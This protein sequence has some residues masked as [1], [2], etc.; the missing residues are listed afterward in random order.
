MKLRFVDIKRSLLAISALGVA[1]ASAGNL[2]NCREVL[3]R[4]R[5]EDRTMLHTSITWLID[6][7]MKILA[8]KAGIRAESPTH[9]MLEGLNFDFTADT[10]L[11]TEGHAI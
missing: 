6:I 10:L 2:Y 5:P 7:G 1:W 9:K 11:W 3:H 8:G 4:A